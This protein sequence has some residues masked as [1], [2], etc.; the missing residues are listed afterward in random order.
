MRE[1]TLG[2]RVS[3]VI[4][5]L[6]GLTFF[7]TVWWLAKILFDVQS[8]ILPAPSEVVESF[9]EQPSYLLEQAWRTFTII[10]VGYVSA[11][12]GAITVAIILTASKTIERAVL[13]LLVALNSVP[14]VALAPLLVVWMGFG[15]GPKIALV[16]V[17]CFLPIVVATTAGLTSTPGDLGELG[18]SLSAT[19]WQ[20]YLK[21]RLPW[22]LPQIF[23]GLKVAITLS[24]I[25]AVVA[26]I[27][28]PDRGLGSVIALS[29]SSLDTARAF[30]AIVLL[31]MIS[32]SLYYLAV[33]AER[34]L[35]PWARE[36]AS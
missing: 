29:S 2:S 10:A 26:E 36:I 30:A 28:N 7:V 3:G 15:P 12:I 22:A 5:P 11:A 18:R 17:I 21:I 19:R 35:L 32:V 25:G 4:L 14:K 24:V 1:K 31:A 13:P 16:I 33:T 6:L 27:Q 34:L 9:L 23:V 20:G 8:I